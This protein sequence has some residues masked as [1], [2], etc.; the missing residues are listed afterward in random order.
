MASVPVCAPAIVGANFSTMVQFAAGRTVFPEHRSVDNPGPVTLD[1]IVP[2][3]VQVNVCV[4]LLPKL[5]LPN[6]R[7]DGDQ[8]IPDTGTAK[9]VP[10]REILFVPTLVL[11]LTV[12]SAGPPGGCTP[13]A[14]GVKIAKIE[15]VMPVARVFPEQVSVGSPGPVN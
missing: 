12:K 10:E 1:A 14:V 8:L 13:T 9:P 2:L 6:A 3:D 7:D 5:T 11:S 15:Q 4:T